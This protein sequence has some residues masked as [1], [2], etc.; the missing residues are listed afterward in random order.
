MDPAPS[1]MPGDLLHVRHKHT[2]NPSVQEVV[3]TLEGNQGDGFTNAC[4]LLVRDTEASDI[5]VMKIF[6]FKLSSG[7]RELHGAD[8]FTIKRQEALE[9]FLYEG[10]LPD[11]VSWL[12][13]PFDVSS[14]NVPGLR[15][16]LAEGEVG[17]NLSKFSLYEI[18]LEDDDLM[19]DLVCKGLLPPFSEGGHEAMIMLKQRM[20]HIYEDATFAYLKDRT[21]DGVF[22]SPFPSFSDSVFVSRVALQPEPLSSLESG[23][24]NPSRLVASDSLARGH[25]NPLHQD[26]SQVVSNGDLETIASDS[27]RASTISNGLG[28]GGDQSLEPHLEIPLV[29][30]AKE[31][32]SEATAAAGCRSFQE[33]P[34][35]AREDVTTIHPFT[36]NHTEHPAVLMEYLPGN[37]MSK[38]DPNS[39]PPEDFEVIYQ[40]LRYSVIVVPI[41]LELQIEDLQPRN[42]ILHKPQD[43]QWIA[44]IC[45]MGG[46]DLLNP[47]SH[48]LAWSQCRPSAAFEPQRYPETQKL[49]HAPPV[50]TFVEERVFQL[51]CQWFGSR[52]QPRHPNLRCTPSIDRFR[53]FEGP[54]SFY[55]NKLWDLV[56]ESLICSL[57]Q[58]K[59]QSA[60]FLMQYVL[61]QVCMLM[62]EEQ[63]RVEPPLG[64]GLYAI[65][66]ISR[67]LSGSLSSRSTTDCQVIPTVQAFADCFNPNFKNSKMTSLTEAHEWLPRQDIWSKCLWYCSPSESAKDIMV[68]MARRRS[69]EQNISLKGY[70]DEHFSVLATTAL[71][72][73]QSSQD[74][75]ISN[76]LENPNG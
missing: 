25:L 3:R 33:T 5:R 67:L 44:Y 8:A 65:R 74:I 37:T 53:E 54:R 76:P 45:D 50:L 10:C 40:A 75:K 30:N 23:Y 42:I 11:L 72:Q 2:N 21:G 69:A 35:D 71:H 1:Y 36:A 14:S 49:Y 16:R 29:S 27:S 43:H 61:E 46:I 47:A 7:F 17:P 6:D 64:W 4:C 39:I 63:G 26:S 60:P 18:A 68:E 51:M 73:P 52:Y 22:E 38:L 41:Y 31:S 48:Q 55:D 19:Q 59:I 62:N 58:S 57:R 32:H 34:R 15:E 12:Y 66:R 13:E 20:Q 24:S 56:V 9:Q 70:I 28:R